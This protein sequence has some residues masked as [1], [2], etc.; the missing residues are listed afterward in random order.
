MARKRYNEEDIQ[1]LQQ[2]GL[3][4]KQI[5]EKLGVG[6]ASIYRYRGQAQNTYA[7]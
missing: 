2:E 7:Q 5:A 1:R 3:K 4:P 6:V